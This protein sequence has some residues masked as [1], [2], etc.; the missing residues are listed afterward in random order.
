MTTEENIKA[1]L[2]TNFIGFRDDIINCTLKNI[3][4]IINSITNALCKTT[5]EEEKYIKIDAI[6]IKEVKSHLNKL[7]GKLA[8]SSYKITATPDLSYKTTAQKKYNQNEKEFIYVDTDRIYWNSILTERHIKVI[9]ETN[10]TGFRDDVID[11]ALKNIMI[12]IKNILKYYNSELLEPTTTCVYYNTELSYP[13]CYAQK[14][15]PYTNCK[16]C[17]E[18]YCEL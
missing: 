13:R 14:G 8:Q 18:I 4:I 3:M 2:E 7:Y 6:T 5:P 15:A 17:K 10:F 12:I 9:L 16:G 1:I 11:C